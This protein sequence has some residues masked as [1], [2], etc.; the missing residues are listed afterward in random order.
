M[1]VGS[2][3]GFTFHCNPILPSF[4]VLKDQWPLNFGLFHLSVATIDSKRAKVIQFKYF[5]GRHRHFLS[6]SYV[7]NLIR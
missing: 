7:W 1:E 4:S 2:R 5:F 6:I 3:A